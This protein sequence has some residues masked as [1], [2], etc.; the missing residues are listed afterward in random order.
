MFT[1]RFLRTT[2]LVSPFPRKLGSYQIFFFFFLVDAMIKNITE[3][4]RTLK[5]KITNSEASSLEE[6]N[7]TRS[8]KESHYHSVCFMDM[9]TGD[10][11]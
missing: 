5:I 2:S 11:A 1:V 9:K 7:K 4:N 3:L 6:G 8:V 10:P